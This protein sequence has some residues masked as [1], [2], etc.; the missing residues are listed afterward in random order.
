MGNVLAYCD[1]PLSRRQEA[2]PVIRR[3]CR[4]GGSRTREHSRAKM[5]AGP[6][7]SSGSMRHLHRRLRKLSI[8]FIFRWNFPNREAYSQ[9]SLSA[10]SGRCWKRSAKTGMRLASRFRFLELY[11]H[12][13][14]S[15]GNNTPQAKECW[16]CLNRCR[17]YCI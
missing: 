4:C 6:V 1:A 2:P 13:A 10:S 3:R 17:T 9:P 12:L 16:S 7:F 11:C 5:A 15:R 8:F 14:A